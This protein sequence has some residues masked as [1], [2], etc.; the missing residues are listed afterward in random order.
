MFQ[1][2]YRFFHIYNHERKLR[3]LQTIFTSNM[4]IHVSNLWR[5]VSKLTKH[6]KTY[7]PLIRL[8]YSHR[9]K[10]YILNKSMLFLIP[11]HWRNIQL[12]RIY[13]LLS[14]MKL[15]MDT[16]IKK[17]IFIITTDWRCVSPETILFLFPACWWCM[18]HLDK[19]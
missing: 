15:K 8:G 6:T 19:L 16:S 12:K 10:M 17:T 3:F 7:I 13:S 14:H 11:T 1:L 9:L 18:F 5:W 2:L 4:E